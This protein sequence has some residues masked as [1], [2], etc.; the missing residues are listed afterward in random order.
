RPWTRNGW[1]PCAEGG[2]VQHGDD[3][4]AVVAGLS[5]HIRCGMLLRFVSVVVLSVPC[6]H[7]PSCAVHGGYSPGFQGGPP[8]QRGWVRVGSRGHCNPCVMVAGGPVQ[9]P[10][11]Q[12]GAEVGHRCVV[13]GGPFV[14]GCEG[15]QVFDV[16]HGFDVGIHQNPLVG[17]VVWVVVC[18][19]VSPRVGRGGAFAPGRPLS[20]FGHPGL[21][22]FGCDSVML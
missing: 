3:V 12:G 8:H 10:V 4:T 1:S 13:N 16:T 2:R 15:V 20:C 18:T 22:Y 7:T 19:W 11:L 9:G 5:T 17:W 21:P 6:S 14:K